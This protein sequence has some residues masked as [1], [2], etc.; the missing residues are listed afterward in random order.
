MTVADTGNAIVK[1][2]ERVV[3]GKP[4]AV[5]DAVVTLLAG[6]HL[7]V[8]DQPGLGKTT[9]AKAL[10]ASIGGTFRRIQG[11]AD[12]VPTELTG[13]NVLQPG[14]SQW[15]FRPGPLFANVTLVDE[16]NRA[17]P[18]AQ[19]ALL[20]A[21][22]ERQVTVDGTTYKLPDPFMVIATQ[23]PGD[24]AGT[25]P[26]VEGQR[27]RFQT[28]ISLG[29]P[30]VDAERELLLGFGGHAELPMLRVVCE[31]EQLMRARGAVRSVLVHPTI[32]DYVIALGQASRDHQSVRFGLSPRGSLALVRSAQAIAAMYGRDYVV[33][34]HVQ[35]VAHGV[36]AHRLVLSG[37]TNLEM[38]RRI[39]SE[40]VAHVP[41][42]RG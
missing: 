33:P 26:L 34:D 28:A 35:A 15:E 12:L 22:A 4:E 13:V 42:P 30:S 14:A 36:I 29:H 8:E 17:T 5:R 37:G 18:R 11:T 7:L 38:A 41:V 6:G 3:R 19:S 9:L 39:V 1:N 23:N 25:F 10:A 20:E 27:D 32:A 21:M 16:L 40:I 24:H 31:P 2:I